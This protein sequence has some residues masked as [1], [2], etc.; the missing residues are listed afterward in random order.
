[1]GAAPVILISLLLYLKRQVDRR[2][3]I[4]I[5]LILS[6]TTLLLGQTLFLPMTRA[7]VVNVETKYLD[8]Y[9]LPTPAERSMIKEYL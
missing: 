2:A 8:S 7:A 3:L 4:Q 6:Q 1:M 5:K 9:F